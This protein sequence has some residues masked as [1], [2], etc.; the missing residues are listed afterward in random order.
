MVLEL[1][2]KKEGEREKIE[3]ERGWPWPR[4]ERREGREGGL[5]MRIR[6]VKA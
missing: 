6:K 1:Y 5:E 2:Y 4:G 3:R